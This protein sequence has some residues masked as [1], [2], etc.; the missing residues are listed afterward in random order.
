MNYNQYRDTL[1]QAL[2]EKKITQEKYDSLMEWMDI[3]EGI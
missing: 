3:L 1:K 2:R